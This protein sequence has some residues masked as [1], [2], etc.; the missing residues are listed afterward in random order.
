MY[1]CVELTTATREQES[2]ANAEIASTY[3]NNTTLVDKLCDTFRG[4]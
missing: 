1:K 2:S 3:A 4:Q